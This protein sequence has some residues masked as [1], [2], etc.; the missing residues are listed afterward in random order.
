MPVQEQTPYTE[1][2]GNGV[3][4]TFAYQFKVLE[5]QD[6]EV[7]VDG[8]IQVGNYSVTGLG[9]DAGGTVV[10][11]VAPAN[12]AAILLV[13]EV[14]L[15]RS[16]DYQE[17]GDLQSSTLD[18][19]FD[20][21]WLAAQGGKAK[22]SSAIRVPLT[23]QVPPLP[24]AAQRANL[25]IVFDALGNPTVSA[26]PGTDSSLRTD[27]ANQA[28][29]TLGVGLLGYINSYAGAVGRP[30]REKLAEI[31]SVKDFGAKG[32]G[33]TDDTAEI[34]AAFDYIANLAPGGTAIGGVLHFPPGE[35]MVSGTL[36]MPTGKPFVI[37]GSGYGT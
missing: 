34:Q 31:V 37:Q 30:L 12:L 7:Q 21:L 13:S 24:K 26:G 20:R 1:H 36:L 17:N 28:I 35:Y 16:T 15:E 10:F 18:A 14:V 19:D 5:L 29:S 11:D 9:N 2:V 25:F 3:T 23:E 4:T 22:L 8:V 33:V 27:L 6:L 32:D